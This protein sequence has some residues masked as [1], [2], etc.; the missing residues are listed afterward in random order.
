MVALRLVSLLL[1]LGISGAAAARASFRGPLRSS[2]LTPHPRQ[3]CDHLPGQKWALGLVAKKSNVSIKAHIE[4][5]PKDCDA[6]WAGFWTLGSDKGDMT[7]RLSLGNKGQLT[8][9]GTDSDGPFTVDGTADANAIDFKKSYKTYNLHYTGSSSDG[10]TSYDGK[11][12]ISSNGETGGFKMDAPTECADQK[13][14]EA[15][16]P[17]EKHMKAKKEAA[18]P[19]SS[20][21]DFSYFDGFSRYGCEHDASPQAQRIYFKDHACGEVKSCRLLELGMT[22]RLCFD[23]CRAQETAKFFG[24]EYGRDCYCATYIEDFTTGGGECDRQ[25][26][27]DVEEMC[28][29]KEKSSVFEM[30]N[31]GDTVS[32]AETTLQLARDAVDGCEEIANE[33]TDNA[34][35]TTAMGLVWS[36]IDICSQGPEGAMVCNYPKKWAAASDAL[37]MS[38]AEATHAADVVEKHAETLSAAVEAVQ[39][40][41][42]AVTAK[43]AAATELATHE[44]RDVAVK[45]KG[46][47][48]V[49]KMALRAVTGPFDHEKPLAKF[50]E[51]YH[52]LGDV[53]GGWHGLCALKPIEGQGF[54]AIVKGDPSEA[55][56]ICGNHCLGLSTGNSACVAFNFQ[57]RNGLAACQFLEEKGLVEPKSSL[58]LAIPI[59]EVSDTLMES[60]GL[61][62]LGCYTHGGFVSGHKHGPLKT[63]VIREVT[64]PN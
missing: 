33:A 34:N 16:A 51:L 28:G 40:A 9:S 14:K 58:V 10:G 36:K 12:V 37:V 25:C 57:Y 4:A 61:G 2:P 6:D 27:G 20:T 54:E 46:A 11:W 26:E 50:D 29:G 22:P 42:D 63:E 41:G 13:A 47:A 30:H 44:L 38:V 32:E 21:A 53:K 8:G 18:R 55:A 23:F 24:I 5:V 15:K 3:R 52:L 59:F 62:A 64:V 19:G 31:C 60:M 43:L 56:A 45:A 17:L 35:A 39:N 48:A 1:A 49:T 7:L